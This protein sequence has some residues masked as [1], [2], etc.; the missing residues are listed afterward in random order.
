MVIFGYF[1]ECR[2]LS[3][4]DKFWQITVIIT[5]IAYKMPKYTVK[6][7][8]FGTKKLSINSYVVDFI[9]KVFLAWNML[10]NRIKTTTDE[11]TENGT[12]KIQ[13]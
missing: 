9:I 12:C 7:T 10:Y 1:I 13:P 2:K 5:N 4:R 6:V 3:F 11:R 8:M